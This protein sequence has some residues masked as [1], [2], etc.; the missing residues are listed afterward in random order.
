MELAFLV[1]SDT[2]LCT[3]LTR[4]ASTREVN[5]IT[6]TL[7][8]HAYL[9]LKREAEILDGKMNPNKKILKRNVYSGIVSQSEIDLKNDLA[10]MVRMLSMKEDV[11]D[12]EEGDDLI[13]TAYKVAMKKFVRLNCQ[14][15]YPSLYVDKDKCNDPEVF[16][17][18][19]AASDKVQKGIE[20]YYKN[21]HS[22]G[23]KNKPEQSADLRAAAAQILEYCD[24]RQFEDVDNSDD[25][26]FTITSM[27]Q[28]RLSKKKVTIT[29]NS[30]ERT[31]TM[32]VDTATDQTLKKKHVKYRGDKESED[33]EIHPYKFLSEGKSFYLLN[34]KGKIVCTSQMAMSTQV[35]PQQQY[36]SMDSLP[37]PTAAP[38]PPM[39]I[40]VSSV[41]ASVRRLMSI[42]V[43]GGA[44]G[45]ICGKNCL[46]L[47]RTAKYTS[48]Q[49]ISKYRLNGCQICSFAIYIETPMGPIIGIIHEAAYVPEFECAIVSKIQMQHYGAKVCDT[50]IQ[51]GGKQRIHT[52]DGFTIPLS[53]RN[54][55][56]YM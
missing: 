40:F 9:D 27:A 31:Q 41:I 17:Y 30:K 13:F 16:K 46:L 36:H 48:V 1:E 56:C 45:S 43:D 51:L 5:K 35:V 15:R 55:L 24:V 47:A 4:L 7:P 11:D 44:N 25:N 38:L 12:D 3:C 19:V 10:V 54:G 29:D 18:L 34:D 42:Q 26:Q 21:K 50:A 14:K 32:E 2:D 8:Y 22:K 49:E 39:D 37:D 6:E 23:K 53:L 33:G 20:Q 28:N 52:L